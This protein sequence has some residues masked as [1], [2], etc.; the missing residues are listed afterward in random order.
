VASERE[1]ERER[2]KTHEQIHRERLI[3]GAWRVAGALQM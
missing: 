3:A 2:A 1:R